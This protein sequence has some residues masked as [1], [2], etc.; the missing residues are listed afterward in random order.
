MPMKEPVHHFRPGGKTREIVLETDEKFGND[1]LWLGPRGRDYGEL[2]PNPKPYQYANLYPDPNSTYFFCQLD[3]PEGSEFTIRGQYPHCR[4]FQVAL[5]LADPEMGGFTA[6]GEKFVDHFIEPDPGSV[7][8]FV[9]GADRTVENRDYTLRIL[10]EDIPEDD[11][12][13][14]PNTLYAS[15]EGEFQA[16]YRVYQPDQ[17]Y[18]GDAGAGLPTYTATLADGTEMSSEEVREQFNR[19]MLAGIAP[20]MPVEQWRALLNSPDND[21]ELEPETTPARNPP[22][23]NRYFNNAFNIVGVFK[24]EEARRQMDVDVATG[25]GGDPETLFLMGYLS[26]GFGPVLVI[27]GKMPMYPDNYFG[28]DGN[29]LD[30]MSDWETRYMSLVVS[31]APPSGRGTDGISDFQIPLDDDR[32]YTVVVSREEDRPANATDEHGV[33][34]VDWGHRGE[35]IDDELNRE[36]FALILFRFMHNNPD[37]AHDPDKILEPGTEEKIMGPYFPKLSYTDKETFEAEVV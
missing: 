34:W 17:G 12:D 29:G 24:S 22:L 20:G 5:Y 23:L 8:P 4:Y 2:L 14:E 15:R 28:D 6:T 27:R 33:A 30:V 10:R 7:N 26:R 32:N 9:P 16:V 18:L 19:P 11:A 37:W 21:P 36:D 31:E 35:G 25:F 13:R 1:G 3:M